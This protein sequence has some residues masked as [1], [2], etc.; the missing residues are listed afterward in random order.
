MPDDKNLI[1]RRLP[2]IERTIESIQ[3]E[4]DVRVRILGTVI[5]IDKNSLIVDDGTG[6]L[7]ILFDEKPFLRE[8]QLVKIITRILPLIDGFQC[9]GE[10]IQVLDNFDIGLYKHTREIIEKVG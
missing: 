10:C 2:A 9:K 8:G 6:R 7:E 3:P 5:G 4:V 1:R